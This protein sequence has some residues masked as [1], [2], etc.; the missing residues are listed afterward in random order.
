M[1]IYNNDISKVSSDTSA[2]NDT[3][4]LAN[5]TAAVDELLNNLLANASAL[6]ELLIQMTL[7]LQF[8]TTLKGLL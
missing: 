6:D 8:S 2:L 3:T 4:G 1:N 7:L 5:E